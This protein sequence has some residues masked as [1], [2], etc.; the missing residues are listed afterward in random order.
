MA[1]TTY[2]R[3]L[4]LMARL[5]GPDGCPWDRKQTHRTLLKH[6][7]EESAEVA[8]AV[9]KGDMAN[10]C[11]ELGDLLHQIIFHAGIAAEEGRFTMADVVDGLGRKMVRRHPHV[12]G[13][14][15]LK[16][17]RQVMAQWKEIKRK[18]KEDMTRGNSALVN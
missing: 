10:L 7:K 5:R 12:F 15:K 6:L 18:E 14:K 11:E 13:G 17:A 4:K 3:L 1:L 16:T 2:P 9:R 8:R